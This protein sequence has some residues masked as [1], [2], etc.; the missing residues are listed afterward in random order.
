MEFTMKL[1]RFYRLWTVA[2]LAGVSAAVGGTPGTGFTYQGQLK[3]DGFPLSDDVDLKFTLWNAAVNGAANPTVVQHLALPVVNGLFTAHLDFGAAGFDGDARWLQIEV[4]HPAGVGAYTPLSARQPITPAPYALYAFNAPAGGGTLDQAYDFGGPG[5]GRTITA[6]TGAV[7]IAGAGGLTVAGRLGVGTTTPELEIQLN[8]SSGLLAPEATRMGIRHSSIVLPPNPPS[9][10]WLYL[11]AGAGGPRLVRDEGQALRLGT[12][13]TF[14]TGTFV[15]QAKINSNGSL[16]VLGGTDAGLASGGQLVLGNTNLG[17]LALDTNEIMARNNDAAATLYLNNDGGTIALAANST[18]GVGIGTTSPK[19]KL[20]VDGDYYGRGHLYLH[21]YEGD[22]SSG[23]AFVQ[24]R[25]TSTTSVLD[26]RLRTKNGNSLTEAMTL[27]ANGRVGIGT[28]SPAS[29][30]DVAGTARVNVLQI[31]GGADLSENF[32]IQ[33]AADPYRDREGAG[34]EPRPEGTQARRHEVE[35]GMVVAI[36]PQRPGKL[37]IATAAYDSTV[38]GII[39]GA[40]GVGTGMVMA[41][42]GTLADG[43]HPVAL[44]GRVYCMVDASYGAIKPGDLLTTSDTPG[45]AMKVLDRERAAGAI[46]GKAMTFL[47]AGEK[48]LVL[49]LVSLQ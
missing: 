35:P 13:D 4:R 39:S 43:Q 22:G 5:A 7:N 17:N 42:E 46:I 6:D 9:A 14:G 2:L 47:A 19:A 45:H 25:D 27:K 48:G 40:G 49:V 44:T 34:L 36:D 24:A 3:M 18:Y 33:P 1:H 10:S 20:H 11:S 29:L 16:Q 12:E 28:T 32:E 21:A 41:H 8:G 37:R 23:T 30:L 26:L 38:A 15:E 31:D